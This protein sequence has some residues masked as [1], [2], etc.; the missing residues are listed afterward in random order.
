MA[1]K[2]NQRRGGAATPPTGTDVPRPIVD[3]ETTA[4][5]TIAAAVDPA[6][7]V[8][9]EP[10]APSTAGTSGSIDVAFSQPHL[11][12]SPSSPEP[13]APVAADA[14]D[15]APVSSGKVVAVAPAGEGSGGASASRSMSAMAKAGL[16]SGVT[17]LGDG[18]SALGGS[19]SRFGEASRKVPIVGSS[20]AAIGESLSSMG[21]SL[22]SLPRAAKT[23]R[24]RLLV[25]SM[26]VAFA[27]VTSWIVVIVAL[28]LRDDETPDLRPEADAVLAALSTGEAGVK[29]VYDNSSPR[30][31]ELTREDVFVGDMLDLY[32]TVGAYREITAVNDTLITSG[33]GG[34]VAR[35]SLTIAFEKGKSR[36]SVSLHWDEGRWKL[37]GIG[38]EL[39]ADL[40]ITQ[41]QR[42]ARVAA[43]KDPMDGARCD[44]HIAA[45][46]M[47]EQLRDG[48]AAE[49]WDGATPHFQQ[50][51][52]K[53][54]FVALQTQ[55]AAT[56][57][58]YRRIIAVPEAKIYGGNSAVFDTLLEFTRS[59]GV[60]AIFGFYRV[61]RTDPWRLR[62]FKL[63]MPL[64]RGATG[65]APTPGSVHGPTLEDLVRPAP[66]VGSATINTPTSPR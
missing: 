39:P 13:G 47:L 44:L 41:K 3:D 66:N 1:S 38:V 23:R 45:N 49:V 33:P 17:A 64:P 14:F 9:V 25:R 31:Q 60:R 56:L 52:E 7:P 10:V 29:A 4:I 46:A 36:G 40:V 32:A 15:S 26:F 62:S 20:V 19:V 27:L 59:Q 22:T 18:V 61:T 28:Q 24:G 63:V 50:Q 55:N 16:D 58:E 2:R 5:G 6:A 42:E 57:G 35:I 43:C 12:A 37:L 30:L 53:A 11:P 65:G 54:R 48:R 8:P 51:E 21:H 34:R